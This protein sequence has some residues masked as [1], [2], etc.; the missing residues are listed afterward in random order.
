M[1]RITEMSET[2]RLFLDV[3]RE[4]PGLTQA[5]IGRTVADRTGKQSHYA[6]AN[7]Y[8]K[9]LLTKRGWIR[10]DDTGGYHPIPVPD[11]VDPYDPSH[12][13]DL[14]QIHAIQITP[15][16]PIMRDDYWPSDHEPTKSRLE[17]VKRRARLR[18]QGLIN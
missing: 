4:I 17:M 15:Q 9:R 8:V 1:K 3:I 10:R 18:R 5:E 16:E 12:F 14:G 13:A 7:Q 11:G 2:E 6:N